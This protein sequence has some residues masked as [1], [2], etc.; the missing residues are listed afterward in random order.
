M[1]SGHYPSKEKRLHFPTGF[2]LSV[3]GMKVTR[4]KALS[5]NWSLL[6]DL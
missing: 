4:L 3:F 2:L 1:V 6:E 5:K